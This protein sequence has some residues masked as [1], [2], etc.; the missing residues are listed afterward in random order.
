MLDNL[1]DY[2]PDGVFTVDAE[3]RVTFFNRAAEQITGIKRA[4][5]VG[6]RCCD[7]F[8]ASICENACALKQTLSTS[9]PV[10]NKVVYIIDARG[11]KIPIS[12]S[13]AALR[14]ER[15]RIVGG[16]ESFRDLRLV[17]ALHRRIRGRDDFERSLGVPVLA[18]FG[19]VAAR[20]RK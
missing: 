15:G 11:Q 4:E 17:E 18:E 6:R 20:S 3:W 2:V 7:V 13:T 9:R 8:R 14:D 1:L 5:A 19:F 16:V 12:I 10:V